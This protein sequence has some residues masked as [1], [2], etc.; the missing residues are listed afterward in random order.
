MATTCEPARVVDPAASPANASPRLLAVPGL[1]DHAAPPHPDLTSGL[2]PR[3]DPPPNPP[4]VFPA[5]DPASAPPSFSRATG[6]R[7]QSAIETNKFPGVVA[8]VEAVRS[9]RPSLPAFSFNPGASSSQADNGFLSPPLSPPPSAT[10]GSSSRPGGHRHRRG[11]SE[12]VGGSIRDGD[13]IM[14]I[15]PTNPESEPVPAGPPPSANR[16]GRHA[17]RRSAALS[18]HDLSIVLQPPG[19]NSARRGGSAPTSPAPFNPKEAPA[20]PSPPTLP[21]PS[22]PERTVERPAGANSQT[23][24]GPAQPASEADKCAGRARV[25]FSE[26]VEFIPRPLSLISNDTSSTVTAKPGHSVSG[27]IS[28]LMSAPTRAA[29]EK[30]SLDEAPPAAARDKTESRPSTAGAVLERTPSTLSAHANQSSPR[31]RNSIPALV[32]SDAAVESPEPSPSKPPKRW[33]FFGLDP[34]TSSQPS[35]S[36]PFTSSS[37]ELA[38][39]EDVS[40]EWSPDDVST[41]QAAKPPKASTP[42]KRKGKKPTK[43]VKTWAGSILTRKSKPR[44]KSGK[45][46]RP[47]TA[48]L[49]DK[50]TEPMT[51]ATTP[52][53]PEITIMFDDSENGAAPRRPSPEEDSSYQMIDLDAALGPFNTPLP[54]NPEWEAAQKAAGNPKRRLHSA[55]KLRGFSGP[56]MHYHRRTESAPEMVPFEDSRFG[57]PRFGSNS[58]MADVFE[59]DEEDEDETGSSTSESEVEKESDK[60][61]PALEPSKETTPTPEAPTKQLHPISTGASSGNIIRRRSSGWS[62]VEEPQSAP[63]ERT[64]SSSH[65]E[66]VDDNDTVQFRTSNIFQGNSSPANSA[67]PSPRRMLAAR[68]LAPVDVSPLQ[69]PA[70]AHAPVSPYSM[71]HGSSFPSPRSPMSVDAQRISTA[72][73]SVNEETSF[74]SLLL[75]QPGPEV[76]ISADDV[77]SLSSTNSTMTRESVV[78]GNAQHQQKQQQQALP[79]PR[80]QRPASISTAFGRR[81]SSLASL[82]RLISSSHGER[83][84]LSMEV[85]LDDEPDKKAKSKKTKRLSRL[86][87]FWKGKEVESG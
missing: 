2:D 62:D 46:S 17:H 35:R 13:S 5:R 8:G 33:S 59:E 78:T 16:R 66:A 32:H 19:A 48:N 4:F 12:Y 49:E 14:S 53:T 61:A 71:S 81:R 86:V 64:A 25:G 20:L 68:D 83:S 36:R 65:E 55:Q 26:T 39:N 15:S 23:N 82:S 72:P 73:S 6:R 10:M 75:G 70:V 51:E 87:Q 47:S 21:N 85:P 1:D 57:M 31:R 22:E 60:E 9:S 43:K 52:T 40:N 34:F 30:T 74:Q 7:P 24:S 38:S 18:S 69:L 44:A 27:S 29:V 37:A 3:D 76:R 28:S 79:R 45:T 63:L 84:K 50:R 58:T 42:R 41:A 54:H 80:P 56:G 77:P 67:T 11:G